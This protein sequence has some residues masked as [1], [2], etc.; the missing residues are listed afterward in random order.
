MLAAHFKV[1]SQFVFLNP[2]KI[3][4]F[5]EIQFYFQLN[6]VLRNKLQIEFLLKPFFK[7]I[8]NFLIFK[9][10]RYTFSTKSVTTSI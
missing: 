3:S 4:R 9:T 8:T 1:F 10:K 7:N 5:F 6:I 2:F